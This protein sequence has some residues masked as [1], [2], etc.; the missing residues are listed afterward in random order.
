MR[1]TDSSTA[2]VRGIE[3]V[4]YQLLGIRGPDAGRDLPCLP[5]AGRLRKA[6]NDRALA[7]VTSASDQ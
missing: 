4:P 2:S 5:I 1:D 7:K 3:R 6:I